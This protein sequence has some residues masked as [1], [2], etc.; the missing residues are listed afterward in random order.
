MSFGGRAHI[1]TLRQSGCCLDPFLLSDDRPISFSNRQGQASLELATRRK[2]IAD[3][4]EH[5]TQW[6]AV[7]AFALQAEPQ[8]GADVP[9]SEW[10]NAFGMMS[11]AH[12]EASDIPNTVVRVIFQEYQEANEAAQSPLM[13]AFQEQAMHR[14]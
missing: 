7:Y 12:L 13:L 11:G 1:H 9:L 6:R 5:R 4:G 3:V 8:E 14:L 10:V 2:R